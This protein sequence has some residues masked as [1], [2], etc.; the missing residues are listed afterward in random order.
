MLRFCSAL[1]LFAACAAVSK[2]LPAGSQPVLKLLLILV[3]LA[4]VRGRWSEHGFIWPR[5]PQWRRALA[6]GLAIGALSSLGALLL[7]FD[8]L[9]VLLKGYSLPQMIAII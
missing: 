5:Q 2:W 4:L 8:G 1:A 3:S 7:H 9:R 6:P